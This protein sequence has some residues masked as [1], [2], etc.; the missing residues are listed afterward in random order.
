VQIVLTGGVTCRN[1]SRPTKGAAY[2]VL[3]VTLLL[4]EVRVGC[5]NQ[6]GKDEGTYDH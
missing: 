4:V 2:D 3:G 6:I 5:P 1:G